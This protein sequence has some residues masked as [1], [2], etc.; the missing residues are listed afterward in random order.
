[1]M[2]ITSPRFRLPATHWFIASMTS[3]NDTAPHGGLF[4]GI[5]HGGVV[6]VV[7]D[8]DVVDVVELEVVVVDDVVEEV[9]DVVTPEAEQVMLQILTPCPVVPPLKG[10]CSI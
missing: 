3:A 5:A 8:E 9:V 1:M 6:D 2:S 4:P 10:L 7:V